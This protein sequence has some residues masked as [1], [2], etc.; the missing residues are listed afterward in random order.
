[1]ADGRP[2]S[3][4]R[5]LNGPS[6]EG[7][8]LAQAAGFPHRTAV[9]DGELQYTYQELEQWSWRLAQALGR[10]PSWRPAPVAVLT[11]SAIRGV[12]AMLAILRAGG[13]FVVLDEDSPAA[14]LVE[15]LDDISPALVLHETSAEVRNTVLEWCRSAG[16]IALSFDACDEARP[17]QDTRVPTPSSQPAYIAYTSGSTGRPKGIVMPRPALAQFLTA[18][19]NRIGIEPGDRVAQWAPQSYDAAYAEI[20]GALAVGATLCCPGPHDRRD[21]AGVREWL[22]E[23]G[24]TVFQTVPSFLAELVEAGRP[25][26]R[27]DLRLLLVAGEALATALA[28]E[29]RR[30]WP[31]VRLFNLYG[32]S[33]SIL[34]TVMP[35]DDSPAGD[36]VPVGTALDRRTLTVLDDD[37][38]P[39]PAGTVGEIFI[40]SEHLALGYWRRPAETAAAF[41]PDP[42]GRGRRR[43]RTG[44]LGRIRAD[45]VLEFTGRRDLQV[46]IRGRR[47]ELTEVEAAIRR[48]PGVADAAVTAVTTG[49]VVTGLAA[50][51]VPARTGAR[52]DMLQ[53]RH[54]LA[55]TLPG[56]LVPTAFSA[57]A[58]LPRTR[59]GK[60]DRSALARIQSPAVGD[61][62]PQPPR[63]DAERQV[64]AVF[65]EILGVDEVG[66]RSNFF[67]LGGHS[68]SA[69][70]VAS[71]LRTRLGVKVTVRTVLEF[72][73]VAE[74]A[75]RLESPEEPA[76]GTV[77]PAPATRRPLS[78]EQQRLWFLSELYPDSTAYNMVLA[79][80]VHGSLELSALDDAFALLVRRHEVL[81]MRV[82][83]VD[84]EPWSANDTQPVLHHVN[85]RDVPFGQ[86]ESVLVRLAA[87]E[88]SVPFRLATGPVMRARVVQFADDDHAL[89]FVVHHIAVDAESF[90]ILRRELSE[91]YEACRSRRAA[92][93]PDLTEQYAD[94]ASW[95]REALPEAL[96]TEQLAYW[97]GQLAG[98][99]ALELPM[100]RPRPHEPAGPGASHR[101]V[102]PSDL[103][104]RLRVVGITAGTTLFVTLLTAYVT[105]LSRYSGQSDITVGVP[106]SRR[107]RP[108]DEDLIGCYVNTLV[109]RAD[110]SGD[111]GFLDLL[112]RTRRVALDAYGHQDLPLDKLVEHLAP[113]RDVR[114]N[115][116]FQTMF[117][118]RSAQDEHARLGDLPAERVPVDLPVSI[119]DLSVTLTDAGPDGMRGVVHYRAD[120]LDR[121]VVES[122]ARHYVTLLGGLADDAARPVSRLRLL[123]PD[124]RIALAT[125]ATWPEPVTPPLGRLHELFEAQVARTPDAPAV[126][127]GSERLTYQELDSR[128]DMLASHLRAL[129]TGPERP[130]GLLLERGIQLV[131]GMLGILKAGGGY[132]PLDLG[133]PASRLAGIVA[134]SDIRL[135]VTQD[136]LAD[137][138]PG[139]AT[140][141]VPVDGWTGEPARPAAG[142]MAYLI[143]TSGSTGRP[144]AVVVDHDSITR[145]VAGTVDFFGITPADRVYQFATTTFD[146]HAEE[147]HP[148]LCGGACL[149]MRGPDAALSVRQ[150][151]DDVAFHRVTVLNLPTAYWHELCSWLEH[152]R[153]RLPASVRLVVIGGESALPHALAVWRRLAGSTVRLLNTYGPT[154]ATV[155]TVAADLTEDDS[156]T[157][158]IGR[159]LPGVVARVLDGDMEPVPAGLF[160]E[161][162]LGGRCLARGYLGQPAATARNFVPDPFAPGRLFR[163]GDVAR[164]R[165]DG[166]LELRGR[167]D[168]QVKIRGY[169]AE[170]GEIENALR[171][172]PGIGDAVVGVAG[173]S[174]V[175]YV[176][177]APDTSLNAD[178]LRVFLADRLPRYML[179]ADFVALPRLPLTPHGKVD[180]HRLAGL[181]GDR[182]AR[183]GARVAPR[184]PVEAAVAE[185]WGQVLG[186]DDFGVE[187]NLFDLGA[188]SLML[189]KVAA[190]IRRRF[191]VDIPVRTYFERQTVAALTPYVV[192][193]V[194]AKVARLPDAEVR[195][196]LT[197]RSPE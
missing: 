39:C 70:R 80:R 93:I 63:S 150:L 5:P 176:V 75:A 138:V 133:D 119:V 196:L 76:V 100:A 23:S 101:F 86:R 4:E 126:V 158:P 83:V 188:H 102:L 31:Q 46:K 137:R 191:G 197:G 173:S 78:F 161:L 177:A 136:D 26:G 113:E 10:S 183:P 104:D 35:V 120:L 19:T 170:L 182:L 60:V 55:G 172:H 71:R 180:R 91:L 73:T 175:A 179:P 103:T 141:T 58:S 11:R 87:D 190:R 77:R 72:P 59:N 7:L 118:V 193:A 69:A 22:D 79:L 105:V 20:F 124:E 195:R 131:T 187:D 36:S 85:R 159:P 194:A 167:T 44:D 163:T 192:D 114:R 155:A 146:T 25:G 51:V 186:R 41:L 30:Q 27:S 57:L 125:E 97:R 153:Q 140:L 132:V 160:G 99:L 117:E 112:A 15:Q 32:P 189:M 18:W 171:G 38:V 65:A 129:G 6:P 145:F 147:I 178:E 24:V 152:E 107:H 169:R 181:G 174:L 2:Q 108:A 151:L 56:H 82:E 116:L 43:Y 130:V 34:A 61:G 98:L 162:Y 29:C 139:V 14:R 94:Y 62:S 68:L 154:E 111:P 92:R 13:T 90:Q 157:V 88:A 149:I 110:L 50:H 144:K 74:L 53:L 37:G 123:D 143:S 84:G 127:H 142:T 165:A 3:A 121:P 54:F 95:Q 64:A 156:R 12:V 106:V 42:A 1:M 166:L 66:S 81:R 67:V 16:A 21:A 128:A 45:G 184:S 164:R 135:V 134:D 115:P 9:T 96:A 148:A 8:F 89:V 49:A 168:T 33:E 48:Y 52:P 122:F 28:S 17:S 40:G 185:V 109:F 47:A